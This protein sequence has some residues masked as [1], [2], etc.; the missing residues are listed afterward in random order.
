MPVLWCDVCSTWYTA[1]WRLAEDHHAYIVVA[2]YCPTC[3]WE[4]ERRRVRKEGG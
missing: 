4:T 3:G 2:S 1:Y